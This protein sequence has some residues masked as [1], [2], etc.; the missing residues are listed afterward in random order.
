MLSPN[1]LPWRLASV[2]IPSPPGRQSRGAL[3]RQ[4]MEW[5]MK[6]AESR[7]SCHTRQATA[8][9]QCRMSL[10]IIKEF[11]AT[12][13]DWGKSQ[14]RS[15]EAQCFKIQLPRKGYQ[16]HFKAHCSICQI[17]RGREIDV[18]E[19]SLQRERF[20]RIEKL[21]ALHQEYWRL[22]TLIS[23]NEKWSRNFWRLQMKALFN[24]SF[25]CPRTNKD[26]Q[27]WVKCESQV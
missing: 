17:D 8:K 3:S 16:N 14:N 4:K 12:C 20:M 19:C 21:A 5:R 2:A 11:P 26:V 22:L 24:D 7:N 9:H 25:R 15:S 13:V 27:T 18:C 1:L 10:F 6:T 23:W